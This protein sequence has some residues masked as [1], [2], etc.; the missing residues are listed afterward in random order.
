MGDS[1]RI[2]RFL[3]DAALAVVLALPAA[4]ASAAST[5]LDLGSVEPGQLVNEFDLLVQLPATPSLV[6]AKKITLTVKDSADGVNF[7]AIDTLAPQV[8]TG[9]GGVGAGALEKRIKLPTT[10]RRYVRIDAAVENGGGDNTVIS[11]TLSL[12]F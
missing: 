2:Q 5:A 6:D 11:V 7:T 8:V 4:N 12:V 3:I 9:A 10:V 1:A